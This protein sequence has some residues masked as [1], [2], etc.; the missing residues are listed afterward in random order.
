[1][2]VWVVNQQTLWFDHI[3]YLNPYDDAPQDQS[4]LRIESTDPS[5]VKGPAGAWGVLANDFQF[6]GKTSYTQV[7]QAWFEFKFT[8]S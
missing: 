7:S 3:Q 1:M 6:Y 8:G 4:I 5:I 2:K